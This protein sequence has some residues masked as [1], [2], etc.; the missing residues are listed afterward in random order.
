MNLLYVIP[1]YGLHWYLTYQEKHFPRLGMVRSIVEPCMVIKYGE[2]EAEKCIILRVEDSLGYE[3][4]YFSAGE[5]ID[6]QRF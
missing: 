4:N 3:T 2:E 1:E 6:D 5:E